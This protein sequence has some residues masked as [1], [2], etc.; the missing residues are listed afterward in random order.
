MNPNDKILI[1][2]PG[3]CKPFKALFIG[4]HASNKMI[5]KGNEPVVSPDGQPLFENGEILAITIDKAENPAGI[6]AE[7]GEEQRVVPEES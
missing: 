7:M 5:V 4:Y 3:L 2:I 1:S 6:V